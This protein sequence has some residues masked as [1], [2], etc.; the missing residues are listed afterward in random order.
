MGFAE[1]V[2]RHGLTQATVAQQSGVPLAT[3]NDVVRRLRDPRTSTV[4][5]LLVFARRYEPEASYEELF[6]PE[7]LRLGA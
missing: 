6:A 5:K 7:L 4:N 3:V 2:Q 1:L